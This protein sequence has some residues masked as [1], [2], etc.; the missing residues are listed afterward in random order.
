MEAIVM[1]FRD[2]KGSQHSSRVQNLTL[3]R[4]YDVIKLVCI[5]VFRFEY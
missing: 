4:H 3:R 1:S 2:K 5:F